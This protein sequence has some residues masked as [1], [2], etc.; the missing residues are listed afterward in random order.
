MKQ[1]RIQ[2]ELQN[3]RVCQKNYGLIN[4][5]CSKC[6]NKCQYCQINQN[7]LTC[8]KC[9]K[10]YFLNFQR[11]CI[12]CNLEYCEQCYHYNEQ[13]NTLERNFKVQKLR[14]HLLFRLLLLREQQ[15]PYF[16]QKSMQLISLR[17]PKYVQNF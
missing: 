13:L 12:K 4:G 3:C 17:L 5:K 8:M 16:R 9:E 6:P 11:K 1:C 10:G 15:S 7:K 2:E 14:L